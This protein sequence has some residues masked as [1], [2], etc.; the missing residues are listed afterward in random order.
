MS[1]HQDHIGQVYTTS[2]GKPASGGATVTLWGQNG[3]Q[4][5]TMISGVVQP[6][7]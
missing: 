3:P 4:Q 1:T 7:K 6:N 2:D 5:G